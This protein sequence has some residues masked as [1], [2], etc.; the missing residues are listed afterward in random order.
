MPPSDAELAAALDAVLRAK[1]DVDAEACSVALGLL[2]RARDAT[3]DHARRGGLN[4]LVSLVMGIKHPLG[5]PP[6]PAFEA[7]RGAVFPTD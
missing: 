1:P 7:E 3:E 6:W 2:C 5:V 4:N